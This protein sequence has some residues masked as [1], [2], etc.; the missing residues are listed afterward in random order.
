[1]TK[2]RS[3]KF[4]LMKKKLRS[5]KNIHYRDGSASDLDQM[6]RLAYLSW[7][8]YKSKLTEENWN[9]L[10]GTLENSD[11]YIELLNMSQ[12]I[13]CE[14]TEKEVVGMAFLVPNGHPT[15]I[16]EKTWSY[17]RFVSVNPTFRGQ[18]IGKTLTEKCINYAR[19]N[20]EKIVALHTSEMMESAISIYEKLG[21]TIKREL[22]PRLG[23]KYWLYILEL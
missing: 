23:K 4:N 19:G 13:L 5:T 17:I 2:L 15:Y 20:N 21:F 12:C 14:T 16:Y 6:M 9:R 10:K 22:E 11:T 8:E 3:L 18:K 7:K 1:M